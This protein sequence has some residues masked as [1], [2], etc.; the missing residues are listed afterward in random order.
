[1][2]AIREEALKENEALR[3]AYEEGFDVIFN[4]GYVSH[5]NSRSDPIGGSE[6]VSGCEKIPGL[7]QLAD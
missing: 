6:P 1:M 7:T 5:P 2:S 4:Y 3:E